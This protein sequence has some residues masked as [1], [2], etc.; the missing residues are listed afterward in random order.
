MTRCCWAATLVLLGSAV[1]ALAQG[2]IE[3]TLV[4]PPGSG[5]DLRSV[6]YGQD[7]FVAVGD[8]LL[9]R[10]DDGEW[11]IHASPSDL[12]QSVAYG[13]HG[14]VAVGSGNM[15]PVWFGDWPPVGV[16]F[17]S[18]DGVDW[19]DVTPPEPWAPASIAWDGARYTCAGFDGIVQRSED[20]ATWNEIITG[21]DSFVFMDSVV[22]NDQE[23]LV[24]HNHRPI[25]GW[26]WP[27]IFAS[28][29]H[30]P[31]LQDLEW[32]A[33]DYDEWGAVYAVATRG[34]SVVVGGMLGE[35]ALLT[36]SEDLQKWTIAAPPVPGGFVLDLL[37]VSDVAFACGGDGST[38]WILSSSDG[39]TWP[40][41][42]TVQTPR[43]FGL[44][45]DGGEIV[46]V[47]SEGV[48]VTGRVS[49][50]MV[51]SDGLETGDT[52]MWSSTSP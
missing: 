22:H 41:V 37:V 18:S 23:I 19:L 6:T 30:G 36:S 48:V 33:L 14:F 5:G 4:R 24:G 42:Y 13:S 51:F 34:S 2:S 38:A 15:W 52:S 17:L 39:R 26:E 28:V 50:A 9:V 49:L 47:G 43:L 46:A 29:F 11:Q 21:L 7:R 40:A 16:M 20:G 8:E 44:A 45:T 10:A 32:F 12:L 27:F 35:D 1:H 3:W 25:L 31:E